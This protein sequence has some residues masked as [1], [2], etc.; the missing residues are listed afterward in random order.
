MKFLADEGID[1]SLVNLLRKAGYDTF[2]QAESEQGLDDVFILEKANSE[3]R[4]LITRDMD[5]G[6][7]AWR[8]NM[9]H[10]GIILVRAEELSSLS[11]S[12]LVAEFISSNL[13]LLHNHFIVLQPGAARIRKM[14][15]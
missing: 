13:D 12:K 5:F 3:Q 2:Y 9:I 4:I 14:H 7:L 1:K 8:M 10:T 11:R 6:E 15:A